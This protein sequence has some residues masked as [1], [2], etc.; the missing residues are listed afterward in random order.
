MSP[1]DELYVARA[2][3][4]VDVHELPTGGFQEV[5]VPID[6][7]IS[8]ISNQPDIDL[9][10][11]IV[12]SAAGQQGSY[13]TSELILTNRSTKDAAVTFEYTAAFGGGSGTAATTL[14]AGRQSIKPDA[15]EYLR[16]LGI[17][18]PDTGSRGGTLKVHFSAPSS[19]MELGV[20]ARTTTPAG[21][22]RVGLAYAGEP[23]SITLAGTSY[24]F[25]LRQDGVDRS[26]VA[27]QNTGGPKDGEVVLRL[28]VYSGDPG[29]PVSKTLP[30]ERL[31]PGVFQQLNGILASN[32]LSL[33]RGYV[34]IERVGGTAPYYAYAVINDQTGSNGSF[35]PPLADNALSRRDGWVVPAVVETASYS[36]EVI[37]ANPTLDT[38]DV[39]LIYNPG[40]GQ[41]AE[42]TIEL[43]PGEQRIITSFVQCL[44]D[45]GVAGVGAAGPPYAGPLTVL[46]PNA[47]AQG[48]FAGARTFTSG[49]AGR[50]G[51]FYAAQPVFKTTTNLWLYGLRQDGENRSNLAIVNAGGESD[52]YVIDL[53]NGDTGQKVNT[54]EGPAVAA[55]GWFQIGAILTNHAPGV[56]NGYAHVKRI[57]DSNP[58]LAYAVINDGAAPGE[59]TGDGAFIASSP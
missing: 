57:S 24:L 47:N 6:G 39:Q 3:G 34:R 10:V 35:V 56:H 55:G 28:T 11:P 14:L 59:R 9:F 19:T 36:S 45:Q 32:G 1:S 37:L 23:E 20:M 2:L 44:R 18:I 42:I 48:V 31:V 38:R 50:F 27:L 25:G 8:K 51:V 30:D 54:L 58:F 22:G 33:S 53:Y 41:V 26:N 13:F 21:E 7:V 52:S 49:K 46:D 5:F 40:A 15:M 4:R 17:P 16:A 43:A 29:D 12:L